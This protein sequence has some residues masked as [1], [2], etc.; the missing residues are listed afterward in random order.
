VSATSEE[1]HQLS[2]QKQSFSLV[3]YI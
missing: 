2:L 1:R 3:G